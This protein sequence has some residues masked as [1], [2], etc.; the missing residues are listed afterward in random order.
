MAATSAAGDHAG[1]RPARPRDA[2]RRPPRGDPVT[3]GQREEPAVGTHEPHRG[4]PVERRGR[5]SRRRRRWRSRRWGRGPP[6]RWPT[7]PRRTRVRR[8][9]RTPAA[10]AP[11]RRAGWWNR[12][13][14]A[15]ATKPLRRRSRSRSSPCRPRRGETRTPAP[16]G[17]AGG[18]RRSTTLANGVSSAIGA[19]VT[20]SVE[21]QTVVLVGRAVRRRHGEQ[22]IA[23]T[24]AD[25]HRRRPGFADRRAHPRLVRHDRPRA[26]DRRQGQ[27]GEQQ[28]DRDQRGHRE[29]RGPRPRRPAE[30]GPCPAAPDLRQRRR[31]AHDRVRERRRRRDRRPIGKEPLELVGLRVAR[32]S[33]TV[34]DLQLVLQ[35]APRLRQPSFDRA[36]GPAEQP[37]DLGDRMVMEV[38][39]H[40]DRPLVDREPLER[41]LEPL[42]ARDSFRRGR[43]APVRGSRRRPPRP[44]HR[45][46]RL[47]RPAPRGRR[48][49]PGGASGTR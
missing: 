46:H 23:G 20:P 2:V 49:A 43:P 4:D 19:Q 22:R 14:T 24:A 5:A 17:P 28:A 42:A 31:P 1:E 45:R 21:R 11:D 13:R 30:P 27:Q 10:P 25:H 6:C 34:L 35:G 44:A 9:Q 37:G 33:A 36:F 7:R 32:G 39:E 8:A 40:E 38:V 16:S 3:P 26:A 12:R 48:G 15:D 41:P 29:E 47:R 18:S